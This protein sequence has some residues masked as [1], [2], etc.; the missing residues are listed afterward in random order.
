MTLTICSNSNSITNL[1][2]QLF[3]YVIRSQASQMQIIDLTG[4][5]VAEI[6]EAGVPALA[7]C[8]Q[9]RMEY[10][11]P[12]FLTSRTASP[13]TRYVTCSSTGLT[14]SHHGIMN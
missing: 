9:N 12:Q 5:D 8:N 4:G 10:G 11:S 13:I 3:T 14:L 1:V 6:E 2:S 7:Q